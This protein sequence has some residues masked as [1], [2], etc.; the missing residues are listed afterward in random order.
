MAE[1]QK[2]VATML[3]RLL[4]GKGPEELIGAGGLLEGLTRRLLER[5]VKC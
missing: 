5:A 3:D 4:E 2:E 1:K